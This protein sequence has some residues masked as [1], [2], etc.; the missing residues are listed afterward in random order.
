MSD[1]DWSEGAE[2]VSLTTH[3][4]GRG[5]RRL[6]I[7]SRRFVERIAA[8]RHEAVRLPGPVIWFLCGWLGLACGLVEGLLRLVWGAVEHRFVSLDLWVNWHAPWMAPS[9]LASAFLILGM[10][11]GLFRQIAPRVVNRLLPIALLGLGTWSVVGVI[12]KLDPRAALILVTGVMVRFGPWVRFDA[13][14]FRRLARRSAPILV[15]LWLILVVAIGLWPSTTEWRWQRFGSEATPNAPNV[16]LVVLDTVRVDN[17]SL[18][19]YERP[20]TPRLQHW[21]ERGVRFDQAR[22]TTPYTLGTHASLFTG[23]WASETSARVD[24]PLDGTHRTLAEHLRDRGYRT[25]AFVGNI[26]YGSARYGLDRGFLRY[27]D[28][29]DNI[30]R[31]V[32]PREWI[33]S[34]TLGQRLLYRFERKQR[35]F[36]PLQRQRF[37]AEQLN[38]EALAWLDRAEDPNQPFFLFLN[39]FDA[40]DP[41]SLPVH[42]TQPYS[43]IMPDRLKSMTTALE[44]MRDRPLDDP[45]ASAPRAEVRHHTINAYDDAI[46]WIDLQL[47][48]LFGE[49]EA[50]GLLE[51]TLVLVTSDHGEMLGEHGRIGHGVSLDRPVVHVPLILFGGDGLDASIPPGSTITTPV[52]LRDVPRTILELIGDPEPERFPGGS[53]TSLWDDKSRDA[54]RPG[55]SPVLSEVQ[56]MPWERRTPHTPAASGPI[57]LLSD[58]RWAYQRQLHE[59]L[60]LRE[61]LFDLRD[62]PGELRD[63]S[64]EVGRAQ[65]L[66]RLRAQFKSAY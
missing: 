31:R 59:S 47:D 13:L 7:P 12:P 24:V 9:A 41:Y 64:A 38:A 55:P 63:L 6:G 53:L 60:G 36:R 45:E 56:A 26:F 34:C 40:H 51:N 3:E 43:E 23:R 54:G 28:I 33:R 19:G 17:M 25:G 10:I 27:H 21:A 66:R 49:L 4:K 65:T 39:Y 1:N 46:G 20:T 57:W 2:N 30:T 11:V 58:G 15:G 42:T 16:L 48:A 5:L 62:D 14:R 50:R 8:S 29:P 52:S 18:Y 44:A 37:D 61:R 32:T 22:S 35:I